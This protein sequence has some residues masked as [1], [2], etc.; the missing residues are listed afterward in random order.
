MR[1]LTT[2]NTA[3]VYIGVYVRLVHPN[4]SIEFVL[5]GETLPSVR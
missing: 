4:L 1:L 3:T 5:R 2:Y